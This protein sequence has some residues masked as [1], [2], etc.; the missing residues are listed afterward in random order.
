MAGEDRRRDLRELRKQV[1]ALRDALARVA[2]PY[3]E[4]AGYMEQ[5]QDITR[6][7]FRLLDLYARYGA[8]SPDLAVPPA[9]DRRPDP[10]RQGRERL[11]PPGIVDAPNVDRVAPAEFFQ[12]GGHLML[13]S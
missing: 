4:I 10:P 11:E 13:R 9:P 6:G 1:E 8:I 2:G 3:Q 12:E 7:Y 5:L